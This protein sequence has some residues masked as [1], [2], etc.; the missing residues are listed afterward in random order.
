MLAAHAQ[1]EARSVPVDRGGRLRRGAG[2]LHQCGGHRVPGRAG[3]G[4]HTGRDGL[5]DVGAGPGDGPVDHRPV[6]GLPAAGAHRLVDA[7]CRAAGGPRRPPALPGGAGG[8]AGT[9]RAVARAVH[10]AVRRADHAGRRDAAVRAPDGQAADGDCRGLAGRRAGP[11]RAQR[12]A[13]GAECAVAGGADGRSLRAGPARLAALCG[14]GRA[15]GG[16]RGGGVAG[17]PAVAGTHIRLDAAGVDDAA[18]QPLGGHRRGPAA[19]H[20]HDGLAEPARRCSAARPAT[21]R[22]SRR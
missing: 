17:P 14:A 2:G 12:R 5:V 20:R 1:R 6:V 3:A 9:E 7:R 15:A 13:V 16:H 10:A 4:G 22:R 18:V 21:R 11:L 8:A 19:V